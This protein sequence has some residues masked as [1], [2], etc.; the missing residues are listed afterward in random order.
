MCQG[1]IKFLFRDG[2]QHNVTIYASGEGF[3]DHEQWNDIKKWWLFSER[4][5]KLIQWGDG[6]EWLLARQHIMS[7]TLSLIPEP[8]EIV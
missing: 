1:I 3:S 5:T 4:P 7:I 6:C 2:E 8:L